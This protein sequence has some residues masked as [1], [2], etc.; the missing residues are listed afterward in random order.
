MGRTGDR[1]RVASSRSL[2]ATLIVIAFTLAA[3][4]SGSD[5]DSTGAAGST[6]AVT[7]LDG[8]RSAVIRIVAEGT[9]VDPDFGEQLNAAGSGSGFIISASGLAVTNNHVVTGAGLVRVFLDGND[10]PVNARL[11]GASECSDLAVID[12]AGDGH[13]F[14]TLRE[15]SVNPGLDAYAAGFPLGNPEYTLTRGIISK[16]QANGESEWASVDFVLEHDAQINPGSSGGPLVDADGKV[17]GI[18]YAGSD[19]TN[20]SFAIGL[21]ELQRI[22]DQLSAGEHVNSIGVN[23]QAFLNAQAF[24]ANGSTGIWVA[25]VRSGSPADRAGIRAGDVITRLEGLL[26]ATDGTMSDYCDILRSHGPDDVLAFEIWRAE[27]GQLLEGRLNGDTALTQSFSFAR[28]LGGSLGDSGSAEYEFVSITDDSGVLS[29]QVPSTW[30]DLDG[31]PWFTDEPF[32]PSITVSASLDG[33]R[34]TWT[35]PGLFFGVSEELAQLSGVEGVLDLVREAIGLDENCNW[36][37]R[38]DYSDPFY[39]GQFDQFEGCGGEDVIYISLAALPEDGRFIISVQ[40]Q[41]RAQQ[42][43]GVLDSVLDSFIVIQ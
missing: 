8:V 13:P 15:G 41:L 36:V 19:D 2:W 20:Q 14:L 43:A 30:A 24:A 12:I 1:V 29:V 3:C 7:S 6:G 4:Q 5:N 27:S 22:I 34:N 39:S 11:L 28:Q 35:E 31:T 10:Q 21:A 38:F 33:F 26:L 16:S 40:V 42:D 9:F 32:A 25:S 37:G 18:N 23:G 17:I